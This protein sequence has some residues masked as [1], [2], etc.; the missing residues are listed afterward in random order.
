MSDRVVLT[1]RTRPAGTVDASA[2][3]LHDWADR[4]GGEIAR[5]L[6]R[7]AGVGTGGPRR[8]V[9][10]PGERSDHV[11]LAGDLTMFEGFGAGLA[12]GDIAV[13]GDVGPRVGVRM[14]AG[15]IDRERQRGPGAGLE[16]AGG[17]MDIAGDAAPAR[18]AGH[19]APS[20]A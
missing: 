3:A 13:E 1:L 7:V 6:L 14:R 15:R 18:A 5:L 10:R 9:R 19:R 4:T 11:R 17:L 20:G 16:M 2:L 12:G 8:S